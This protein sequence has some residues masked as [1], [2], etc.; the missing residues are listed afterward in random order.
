MTTASA[1]PSSSAGPDTAR[2]VTTSDDGHDSRSSPARARAAVPQPCSEATPSLMSAPDEA[3]TTTRGSRWSRA[4]GAP[5]ASVALSAAVRAPSRC[6]RVGAHD[7]RP[8]AGAAPGARCP[9]VVEP[10]TPPRRGSHW[11]DETRRPT[12]VV[13]GAAGDSRGALD[14]PVSDRRRAGRDAPLGGPLAGPPVGS[15]PERST[16]RGGRGAVVD[17]VVEAASGPPGA[18]RP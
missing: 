14:R 4:T 18:G 17:V 11:R 12:V 7:D 6:G 3:S 13:E 15:R 9:A 10:G 2:P 8:A 5:A 1:M 16:A